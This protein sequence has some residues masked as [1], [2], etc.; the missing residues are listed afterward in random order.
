MLNGFGPM[1]THRLKWEFTITEENSKTKQS[2]LPKKNTGRRKH[3]FQFSLIPS[4]SPDGVQK[5]N[6]Q[7][8]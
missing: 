2:W 3:L 6:N 5:P 1:I 7:T 4:E 8:Y